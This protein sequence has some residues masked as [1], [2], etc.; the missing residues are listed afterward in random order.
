MVGRVRDGRLRA[1]TV[2]GLSHG[3]RQHS[4]D[5]IES[6]CSKWKISQLALFGSVLRDDFGPESDIDVLVTFAPDARWTLFDLSDMEDDLAAIFGRQVDLVSKRGIEQ[7][8]NPL[9]KEQI[10]SSAQVI[11]DAAA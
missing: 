1:L 11:Y 3:T 2:G 7:S 5:R 8:R 10:L 4:S 6:F 9:R